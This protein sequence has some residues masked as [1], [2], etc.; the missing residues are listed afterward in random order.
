MRL[1][2]L[3]IAAAALVAGCQ[4]PPPAKD[5]YSERVVLLPSVDGKPSAVIVKRATGEQQLNAPYQ[6]IES[7]GGSETRSTS[8]AEDVRRRY[9]DVLAAQ[10]ARPLSFMVFFN[11]GTTDLTPQSRALVAEMQSKIASF[12]APT[13][14]VIGHTD[15]SGPTELNDAL[16]LKRALAVRAYLVGIGIPAQ[17]IDVVGRGEREPLV[18]T[19]PGAVEERN[20]RVE[21][22]LR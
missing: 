5:T 21:I 4:A 14:S 8:S 19:K 10:P 6:A 17:A 13:V 3:A 15:S 16:S 7:E 2:A 22:R 11:L 9:G 18:P 20:R 1:V 12:P